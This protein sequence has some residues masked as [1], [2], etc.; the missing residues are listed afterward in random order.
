MRR[1]ARMAS[2]GCPTAA[3]HAAPTMCA[4]THGRGV[5][6]SA[7]RLRWTSIAAQAG[8]ASSVPGG[9]HGA[10]AESADAA[11]PSSPPSAP[12]YASAASTLQRSAPTA[13]STANA[14][15]W[16]LSAAASASARASGPAS[17]VRY[18]QPRR[19]SSTSITSSS[20]GF[21]ARAAASSL[22]SS[23]TGLPSDSATSQRHSAYSRTIGPADAAAA[24]SAITRASVTP[25]A[26]SSSSR[27][28]TSAHSASAEGFGASAAATGA[29]AWLPPSGG[30][31]FVFPL[32]A[33]QW[34][35][36]TFRPSTRSSALAE[37]VAAWTAA[38][39]AVASR[40]Q[41]AE[42]FPDKPCMPVRRG[43]IVEGF[44][45]KFRESATARGMRL[46]ASTCPADTHSVIVSASVNL[47]A[48]AWKTCSRGCAESGGGS[49][50]SLAATARS[51][52]FEGMAPMSKLDT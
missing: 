46:A 32:R 43:V 42:S 21:D 3:N 14:P 13:A 2:C 15:P 30:R 40:P 10:R 5:A 27:A 6:A 4:C 22:S 11:S 44:R 50:A 16:P 48:S 24:A 17:G 31:P 36:H 52:R 19:P 45:G 28:A 41:R 29:R 9:I 1:I 33:L 51:R 39:P 23:E 18:R 20:A 38:P 34:A 35:D 7:A 26:S 8:S 47:H 37:G 12:T 25:D 49:G